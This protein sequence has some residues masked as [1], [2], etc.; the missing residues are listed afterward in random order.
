MSGST[1]QGERLHAVIVG[2]SLVGLCT[3]LALARAGVAVTVLERSRPHPQYG[4]GLAVDGEQLARVTGVTAF[5]GTRPARPILRRG[6]NFAGRCARL[7]KAT[8]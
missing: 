5:R 4:G 3:A 2:G 1:P 6:W 7:P 8:D